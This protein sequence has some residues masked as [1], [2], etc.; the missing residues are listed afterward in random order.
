[1]AQEL[2]F[3]KYRSLRR[4]IACQAGE[5]HLAQMET[6]GPQRRVVVK[7]L[8]PPVTPERT[9]P[10]C[11]EAKA[12]APTLHPGIFRP[13]DFGVDGGRC[14]VVTEA[15]PCAPLSDL[16]ATSL[17]LRRRLSYEFVAAV[18][19]Q[20]C[21]GL[22][23]AH[24]RNTPDGRPLRLVHSDLSP[25][26]LVVAEGG[27]VKMV[28]FAFARGRGLIEPATRTDQGFHTS[29]YVAPEQLV[30]GREPDGR[31]DLFSLGAVLWEL[32]A[33]K[34][35]FLA[36][37]LSEV[38]EV[39]QAPAAP[40]TLVA[41]DVPLDLA[42]AVARALERDPAARYSSAE[43]MRRAFD[44]VLA[45]RG[46]HHPA[47][48]VDQEC[49]ALLHSGL[50]LA[51]WDSLELPE[52][53]RETLGFDPTEGVLPEG[54]LLEDGPAATIQVS[55]DAPAPGDLHPGS[56]PL[57]PDDAWGAGPVAPEPGPRM[58]PPSVP[59]VPSAPSRQSADP[60]I[61][62][63]SPRG[64][65]SIGGTIALVLITA[66]IAGAGGYFAP[67]LRER[68][69][70]K[71]GGPAANPA[72]V[73]PAG[74]VQVHLTS[75]P[76]GAKI[77]VDGVETGLVSPAELLAAAG[78][79]HAFV[80]K[81]ADH[82]DW[83]VEMEPKALEADKVEAAMVK[84][85]H[86]KVTSEPAG[87]QAEVDELPAFP[88]PG[89]SGAL[90]SGTYKLVVK[91][92]GFVPQTREVSLR[93]SEE[94]T[95]AVTLLPAAEV[96]VKSLPSGAEVFVDG[97]ASGQRTPGTVLV[98]AGKTCFV[99]VRKPGCIGGS[100]KVPAM[101]QGKSVAL[102][103][104]LEDVVHAELIKRSEVRQKDLVALQKKRDE[105]KKK[106]EAKRIPA[107]EKALRDAQDAA[108]DL[109]AELQELQELA[110]M[111]GSLR[112]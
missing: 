39:Y 14:F 22:A 65:R 36:G 104:A 53:Y 85:A 6:G 111:H 26:H 56:V 15:L 25:R 70:A 54:A 64:G 47:A 92:P 49:K 19:S 102:E 77:F 108:D 61:D 13:L 9:L 90:K 73:V 43:E 55:L 42:D 37:S 66:A 62:E 38:E 31:S 33:G 44:A 99:S 69:L 68:F 34:G 27:I 24:S 59:S 16:L 45:R 5:V 67:A 75:V 17:K 1:M 21:A 48:L 100:K 10:F 40:L 28:G 20:V 76:P 91:K 8:N 74:Q 101:E 93:D 107:N 98:P 35:P 23:H 78:R 11:N 84:A 81:L 106:F 18:A 63:E 46:T 83:Q 30:S 94:P 51:N 103:L 89:V 72:E 79:K 57:S 86:I 97:N 112:R 87:A 82:L 60:A 88:T 71:K 110:V 32:V 105:A 109:E 12:T 41:R 2:L 7:I 95:V 58:P 50:R 4:L 80:L 52:W 3:G 96:A 29:Y